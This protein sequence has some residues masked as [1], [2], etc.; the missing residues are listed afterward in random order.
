MRQCVNCNSTTT[1]L[2]KGTKYQYWFKHKEKDGY[3]CKKCYNKLYLNP[4]WYE[5]NSSR[6]LWWTPTGKL[7]RVKE[8]PRKGVCQWCGKKG[9]TNIHHFAEYHEDDPLKDTVELCASCHTKE[10]RRLEKVYV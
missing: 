6:L 2:R 5:K 8:N 4:R 1:T 9:F 3:V 7:I 10:T